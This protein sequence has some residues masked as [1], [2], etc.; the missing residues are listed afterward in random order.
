M[1]YDWTT[2]VG[3]IGSTFMH[4]NLPRDEYV[5]VE[6]RRED[7]LFQG[8][9]TK[10]RQ[11]SFGV[12]PEFGLEAAPTKGNSSAKVVM[13]PKNNSRAPGDLS[14]PIAETP[15]QMEMAKTAE[16]TSAI[17]GTTKEQLNFDKKQAA[18]YKGAMRA[19]AGTELLVD[20]LNA[21]SAYAT[22]EGQAGLNITMAR[23][24]AS[25]A[26][27]RGHQA[28]LDA[29]SEG[30]N[31]G[32]SALL[33]MAAQG[34]DVNGAAV[35]KIQG[36]YEAMGIYNGMREETNSMREALGF[37]LEESNYKYQLNSARIA[38]DT[39]YISSGLTFGAKMYAYS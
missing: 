36:S 6:K 26:R 24:Q 4:P 14:K 37:E 20:V 15:M 31:A 5:T 9:T 32:Q 33:A 38:R 10:G 21:S 19:L 22:A 23:N 8:T 17:A 29:Q 39:S 3:V 25:D 1:N 28:A 11:M 30:Y 16:A 2:G 27:F 12:G 34:Q 18:E 13:T 35:G 7:G